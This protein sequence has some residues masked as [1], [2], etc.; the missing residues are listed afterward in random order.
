MNLENRGFF[1]GKYMSADTGTDKTDLGTHPKCNFFIA[2]YTFILVYSHMRWEIDWQATAKRQK[3]RGRRWG[4]R[5]REVKKKEKD[6][7]TDGRTNFIYESQ[8][9]ISFR[10]VLMKRQYYL[11]SIIKLQQFKRFHSN[12]I[13]APNQILLLPPP[14]SSIPQKILK[15][16]TH[17]YPKFHP[18]CLVDIYG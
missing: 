2:N 6:W 7:R 15:I 5:G 12:L 18:H 13:K 8:E 17:P 10:S 1:H 14:N 4:E 11:L 3:R 9:K 16:S